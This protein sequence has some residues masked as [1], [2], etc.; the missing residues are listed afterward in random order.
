MSHA[1]DLFD[2]AD[3]AD[4]ESAKPYNPKL[5][6]SQLMAPTPDTKLAELTDENLVRCE[7]VVKV[8]E[9]TH[10]FRYFKILKSRELPQQVFVSGPTLETRCLEV[11]PLTERDAKLTRILLGK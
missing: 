1:D 2:E 8:G 7:A 3:A 10:T 6:L 9:A 4:R 11:V 5:S